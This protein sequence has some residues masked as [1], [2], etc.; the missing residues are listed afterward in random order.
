MKKKIKITPKKAIYNDDET[1]CLEIGFDSSGTIIPFLETT[2]KVPKEL[3]KEITSL[4][5]AFARN[6]NKEIEGIQYW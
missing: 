6:L 1:E 5:Y 2:K 4:A 3:P